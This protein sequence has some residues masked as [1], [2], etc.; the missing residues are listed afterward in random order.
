MLFSLLSFCLVMQ[1]LLS[2]T[3]TLE[4]F[5]LFFPTSYYVEP[6]PIYLKTSP[7]GDLEGFIQ[8]LTHEYGHLGHHGRKYSDYYPHRKWAR[9]PRS[10]NWRLRYR[11]RP[12]PGKKREAHKYPTRIKTNNN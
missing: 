6:L 10:R 9:T 7:I 2:Q 5:S 11:D 8:I 4:S 3:T 12:G 1:V